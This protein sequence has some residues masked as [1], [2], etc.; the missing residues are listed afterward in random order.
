M[1]NYEENIVKENFG[2]NLLR[3]RKYTKQTQTELAKRCDLTQGYVSQIEQ[4]NVFP[5]T[6]A[7]VSLAKALGTTVR[8][9]GG[10]EPLN[11][12]ELS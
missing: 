7:M 8:K 9:L 6:N 3:C 5:S 12:V 4:G 1:S 11:Y 2:K 10:L